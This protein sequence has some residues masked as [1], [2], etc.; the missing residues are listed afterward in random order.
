MCRWLHGEKRAN[1]R[2]SICLEGRYSRHSRNVGFVLSSR[3]VATVRVRRRIVRLAGTA[4]DIEA[5]T[6][7]SC[8]SPVVAASPACS[9]C[10]SLEVS[11][12]GI[13]VRRPNVRFART[14]CAVRRTLK[15]HS[16]AS[17]R[18]RLRRQVVSH[19]RPVRIHG[20]RP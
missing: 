6:S 4:D 7:S 10:A 19:L 11:Q 13:R 2:G 14:T 3:L 1:T 15:L 16:S 20:D 17:V 12:L 9:F 8:H 5:N 18:L